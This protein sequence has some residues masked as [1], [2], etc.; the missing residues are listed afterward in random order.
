MTD[1]AKNSVIQLAYKRFEEAAEREADCRKE[2]L[3]D[4]KFVRLG[5]QWPEAVKRDRQIPGQERPMLT[6]N[7]IFQFRNQVINEIRQNSPSIKIRPVGDEANVE[8]AEVRQVVIRHIQDASNAEVAYDTAVECQVDGGLGYFRILT[9]YCDNQS[10]EQDIKIKRIEDPFRVYCGPYTEPDGSDMPWAFITS[11]MPRDEFDALYKSKDAGD[12]DGAGTGDAGGWM[13]EDTVRVAEY[14]ELKAEPREL[15][16]FIDD[17]VMFRDEVM[18][19]F[20]EVPQQLVKDSRQVQQKTCIWRK[21]AGDKV[22]DETEIPTSFIPIIPV[23]GNEVWVEGKRH[24][25][26][27]TRF[28][29]DAQRQYNYLQSANTETLALAPRAPYIIAEGQIEGYESMWAAANRQSFSALVY[30]P[31]TIAG[32]LAP[33]PQ[34]QN[35][36]GTSPGFEAG[37]MRS[38]DDLKASMGIYDSSLGNREGNQSGRAILSQQQQASVGNLHFSDNL[39]RSLKHA[40]R[41]I[42][43]MAFDHP[44]HVYDTKRV[45]R[46]LGEDGASR[47]AQ[48]D[49]ALP[50]AVAEYRDESGKVQKVFNPGV[51]KYDVVVDTGPSYMTKRQEAAAS[52]LAMAQADPQLLQVAGD[53]VVREMD[54]PNADS[55]ADRLKKALPPNLQEEEGEDGKPQDPKMALAAQQMSQMADQMQH[56]SQVLQQ[57]QDDRELKQREL[58]VKEFEAVTRRMA[59]EANIATVPGELHNQALANLSQHLAINTPNQLE[60]QAE[61]PQEQRQETNEQPA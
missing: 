35:P 15:L 49:P 4:V 2:R 26:G 61:T 32:T 57:L 8:T 58:A 33:A 11:S 46:I 42:M 59:V 29:K 27:L 3:D 18:A 14:F 19:R 54:W 60:E 7:R 16:R 12:F 44:Q 23:L 10:F 22:L 21:I 47:T 50:Q 51:G 39:K 53:L 43:E 20:G 41:I 52:M 31:V 28:G 36:P 17:T 56:M 30:K 55:I 40:G 38:V 13:D 24:L 6:I 48:I 9:E 25:H 45:L 1:K 37:M 34:R 5:E